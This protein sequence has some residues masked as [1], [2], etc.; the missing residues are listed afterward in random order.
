MMDAEDE[1]DLPLSTE[2]GEEK[3]PEK[4]EDIREADKEDVEAT[5][6]KEPKNRGFAFFS[7]NW[8]ILVLSICLIGA[9]V[10]LTMRF[11]PQYI[12]H[13]QKKSMVDPSEGMKDNMREE[14]IEPFFIPLSPGVSREVIRLDLS[15]LLDGL[16]YFR[17]SKN[18]IWARDRLYQY[19]VE[20]AKK[21]QDFDTRISVLEMEMGGILKET[22]NVNNVLIRIREVKAF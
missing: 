19:L 14:P 7:R 18:D 9:I 15:V 20:E 12:P 5:S 6:T 11:A 3:N 1:K 22:L 13:W 21:D 8:L 4:D 17:Y 16:A 2:D 10:G